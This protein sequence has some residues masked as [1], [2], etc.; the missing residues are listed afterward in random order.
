MDKILLAFDE[1]GSVDVLGFVLLLGNLDVD[2]IQG[3]EGGMETKPR[4]QL[5]VVVILVAFVHA[6]AFGHVFCTNA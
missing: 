4:S 1:L 3:R 5:R 6:E 2:S